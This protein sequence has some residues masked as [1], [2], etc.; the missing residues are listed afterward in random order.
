MWESGNLYK[1]SIK[2]CE[3]GNGIIGIQENLQIGFLVPASGTIIK[4]TVVETKRSL[5]RK[6]SLSG[7]SSVAVSLSKYTFIESLK[8]DDNSDMHPFRKQKTCE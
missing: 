4:L 6:R 1:R 7:F 2:C 8:H 5:V 3:G